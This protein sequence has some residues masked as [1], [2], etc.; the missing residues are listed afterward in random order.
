MKRM[1]K[2]ISCLV[3]LCLVFALVPA[4][5]MAAETPEVTRAQ[6][7][8]MLVETFSMTVEENNYPDNYYSDLTGEESYYRDILVATEFGVIDLPAGTPFRPEDAATREFAAHTLNY[9]LGFQLGEDAG[10]TFAEASTVTYPVD[11][12]VAV[13]RGWF[14]LSGGK[15]M[16]NQVVTAAERDFMLADAD[17]ILA[18]AEVSD[19]YESV[20]SFTTEV[21][22]IPNGT[23]AE[24]HHNYVVVLLDDHNNIILLNRK[25]FYVPQRK[26]ILDQ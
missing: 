7:V 22:E 17:K 11:I 2:M 6:W 1:Q 13:N 23:Q 21:I 15:F 5:T 24:Y 3:L 4:Q 26:L 10:Y 19:G 14:A 12:Q 8:Q 9:A 20:Y 18:E 16:P 25:I